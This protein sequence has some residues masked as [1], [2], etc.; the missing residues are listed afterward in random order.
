[1]GRAY[2]QGLRGRARIQPRPPLRISIKHLKYET[3]DQGFSA[4]AFLQVDPGTDTLSANVRFRYNPRE[5]VDLYLVYN[6]GWNTRRNLFLPAPPWSRG[7]TVMLKY[8]YTFN[9]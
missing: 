7:R 6:E 3:Y 5:G 8:T 1:M 9:L 2:C 4:A